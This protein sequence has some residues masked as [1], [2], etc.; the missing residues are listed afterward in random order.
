MPQ[1][2]APIEHDAARPAAAVELRHDHL[3]H[4]GAAG[5]KVRGGFRKPRPGRPGSSGS[6][7]VVD[8]VDE[9]ELALDAVVEKSPIV[10]SIASPPGL[11]RRRATIGGERSMPLT[12]TPRAASGRAI[13]PV[14]IASS[15][16]RPSPASSARKS[17][18]GARPPGR[19]FRRN[20][21]P[22]VAATDSSK[23]P[24]AFIAG[25]YRALAVSPPTRGPF[26]SRRSGRTVWCPVPE[27]CGGPPTD[28][29]TVKSGHFLGLQS[30]IRQAEGYC[31]RDG[32]Q[33]IVVDED[34]PFRGARAGQR[35]LT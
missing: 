23:Y 6:D 3:D 25:I 14:P 7:R 34:D 10:T 19:T 12:R 4:E 5:L 15:S 27:G 32:G 2:R 9:R 17:T 11:A 30:E 16:A 1:W 24:S 21:R 20:P 29:R 33:L 35:S 13:R 28:G 18:A 31:A 8:E 26:R 22:Y